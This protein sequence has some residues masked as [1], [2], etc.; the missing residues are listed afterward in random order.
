MGANSAGS[1]A[2]AVP[3]GNRA[4]CPILLTQ[5][6]MFSLLIILTC[7][8][9]FQAPSFADQTE[10][11][12]HAFDAGWQG[13]QTCELLYENDAMIVGRCDFP[14]GVGHE[15]HYH[16]PHFGYV[17]EGATM[18]IVDESGEREVETVTGATWSTDE[19]TVHEAVNIGDTTASYLIV[20]PKPAD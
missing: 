14:P 8:F 15:K 5:P 13:Q 20:E 3:I 17:L 1:N 16:N 11:L 6:K 7:A 12:P 18:R 2:S 4:T 9:V 10:G 19:V